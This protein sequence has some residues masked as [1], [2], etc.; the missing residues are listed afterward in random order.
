MWSSDRQF[1]GVRN[2]KVAQRL[3]PEKKPEIKGQAKIKSGSWILLG[4]INV[5]R[6]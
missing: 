5:G 3:A 6:L 1:A 2:P 4:E